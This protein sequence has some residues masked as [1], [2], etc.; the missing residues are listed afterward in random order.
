MKKLAV[1]AVAAAA[2]LGTGVANAY[3]TGTFGNGFVVPNVVHNG[4]GDTTAVGIINAGPGPTAVSWVFFDPDSGHVQDNCFMM[5]E[6]EFH[7]FVWSEVAGNNTAGVRGYL[8]FAETV[9]W[10]AEKE[11]YEPSCA[12]HA[13]LAYETGGSGGISGAA[14]QADVNNADVAYTPVIDGDLEA[15]DWSKP[16]RTWGKNDLVGAAGAATIGDTLYMRYNIAGADETHVAIWSTGNHEGN[17]TVF[18]CDEAQDC[19]SVDIALKN[20]EQSWFNPKEVVGWPANHTDGF[21][22]WDTSSI[23]TGRSAR[24]GGS[25]PSESVMAY[26]VIDMPAFGAVQS[27]LAPHRV[28]LMSVPAVSQEEGSES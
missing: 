7:P 17:Y 3:T 9:A 12:R 15:D 19:P 24:H 11:R 1:T 26:S 14:F 25:G 23:R 6:E 2:M 20:E 5:T 16:V 22:I 21:I 28:G 18:V 27:I 10:N 4:P 8:V 13:T